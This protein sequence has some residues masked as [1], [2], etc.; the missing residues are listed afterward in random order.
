[1][2][3]APR[4]DAEPVDS[5]VD[6]LLDLFH[7]LSGFGCQAPGPNTRVYVIE[8]IQYHAAGIVRRD[9]ATYQARIET[10]NPANFACDRG[11]LPIIKRQSGLG[12]DC[13]PCRLSC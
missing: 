8:M 11:V 5:P 12:R 13:L 4:P 7:K 2:D 10:P 9:G 1:M 6:I 3:H